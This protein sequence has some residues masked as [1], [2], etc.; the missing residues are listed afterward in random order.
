[1]VVCLF[2][3]ARVCVYVFHGGSRRVMVILVGN[4]QGDK[5]QILDDT[6]CYSH[7]TTSLRKVMNPII[8]PLSEGK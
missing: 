1:M 6:D 8:I 4:G 7:R 2:M 3:W 5:V